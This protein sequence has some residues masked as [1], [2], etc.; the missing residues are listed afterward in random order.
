MSAKSIYCIFI[1]SNK[2][3]LLIS[4]K[5]AW[6][7]IKKLLLI[8]QPDLGPHFFCFFGFQSIIANG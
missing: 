5:R 1:S 7:Q 2:G 6:T 3:F 4:C 8:D